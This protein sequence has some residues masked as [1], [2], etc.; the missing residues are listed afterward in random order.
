[1]NGYKMYGRLMTA[2]VIFHAVADH[3]KKNEKYLFVG[4]V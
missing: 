3:I 1:M 4:I 2:V